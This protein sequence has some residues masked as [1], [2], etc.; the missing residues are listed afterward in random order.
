MSHPCSLHFECETMCDVKRFLFIFSLLMEL[1]VLF[2]SG[3]ELKLECPQK[4]TIETLIIDGVIMPEYM[5]G[6]SNRYI[7]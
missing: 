6:E 5:P 3:P 2:S 7:I 4:Q 1:E